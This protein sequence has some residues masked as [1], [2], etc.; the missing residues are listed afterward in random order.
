MLS[1]SRLSWNCNIQKTRVQF[2][3][4]VANL[5]ILNLFFSR[6]IS[7]GFVGAGTHRGQKQPPLTKKLINLLEQ[8]RGLSISNRSSLRFNGSSR[9]HRSSTAPTEQ[10]WRGFCIGPCTPYIIRFCLFP[11]YI[12]TIGPPLRSYQ[13]AREPCASRFTP[14]INVTRFIN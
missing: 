4:D 1:Q 13:I 14:F 10:R 8:S 9:V 2:K 11:R 7:I 5:S 6:K 12:L 3:C